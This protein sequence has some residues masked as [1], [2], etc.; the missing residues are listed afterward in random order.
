MKRISILLT[1]ISFLFQPGAYVHVS[2][3][4]IEGFGKV[5]A[6]CMV[7]EMRST[8]LGNLSDADVA[9]WPS[10]IAKVIAA[11]PSIVFVIPGHGLFGGKELL[12]HTQELRTK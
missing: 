9:A 12:T 7:K 10:T 1:A 2:V 8:G 11:F 4:D 6:G 5:S 3:S